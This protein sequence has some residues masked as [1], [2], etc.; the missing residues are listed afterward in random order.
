[1]VNY[2]KVYNKSIMLVHKQPRKTIEDEYKFKRLVDVIRSNTN[3]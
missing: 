1:M 2:E 3:R